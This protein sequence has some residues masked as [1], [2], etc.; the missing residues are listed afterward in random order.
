MSASFLFPSRRR[1]TSE[2]GPISPPAVNNAP[3]PHRTL[4]AHKLQGA[5]ALGRADEALAQLHVALRAAVEDPVL[6][7]PLVQPYLLTDCGHS[8]ERAAVERLLLAPQYPSCCPLC[9]TPILSPSRPNYALRDVLEVLARA[10]VVDFAAPAGPAALVAPK[11]C[12][13]QRDMV[14]FA[15]PA[16]VEPPLWAQGSFFLCCA[17]ALTSALLGLGLSDVSEASRAQ[18]SVV[19]RSWGLVM[20]CLPL[21]FLLA[22]HTAQSMRR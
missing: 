12:R 6:L 4:R 11:P 20:V 9:R 21:I 13:V 22:S 1:S 2:P 15:P 17:A 14:S 3:A 19:L 8:F 5:R 16:R 10:G 18:S 7:A